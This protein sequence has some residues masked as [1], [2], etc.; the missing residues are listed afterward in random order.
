MNELIDGM[1]QGREWSA[2]GD[3]DAVR[4]LLGR[5]YDERYHSAAYHKDRFQLRVGKR[6]RGVLPG[7]AQPH[8][9]A[10]APSA[11]RRSIS[12]SGRPRM[13]PSTSRLC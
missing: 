3:G 8:S 5:V 11:S 4:T 12:A 1:A 6:P 13:E 2:M 10:M 9:A 7:S